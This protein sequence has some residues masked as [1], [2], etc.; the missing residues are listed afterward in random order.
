MVLSPKLGALGLLAL[1]AQASGT[2]L[3]AV[4]FMQVVADGAD[5]SDWIGES[6]VN[7]TGN[8]S[9][10][11]PALPKTQSLQDLK[12]EA[13]EMHERTKG[14]FTD[15]DGLHKDWKK[16]NIPADIMKT[17]RDQFS[18]AMGFA[19]ASIDEYLLDLK[20]LSGTM[21]N[22]VDALVE[23]MEYYRKAGKLKPINASS[24]VFTKEALEGLEWT[25]RGLDIFCNRTLTMY[26]NITDRENRSSFKVRNYTQSGVVAMNKLLPIMLDPSMGDERISTEHSLYLTPLKECHD[27]FKVTAAIDPDQARERLVSLAKIL[28]QTKES[29]YPVWGKRLYDFQNGLQHKGIDSL[30]AAT[31]FGLGFSD[32]MFNRTYKY[33]DKLEV[34][35]SAN[36]ALAEGLDR[37]GESLERA[38]FSKEERSKLHKG[39]AAGLRAGFPALLAATA[40]A[41]L[42]LSA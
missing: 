1:A 35:T 37:L 11:F 29:M 32:T 20:N 25:S 27:K 14:I 24:S 42:A 36:V 10:P 33:I 7:S 2:S 4:D 22:M 9:G 38:L 23:K 17:G 41:F 28:R 8:S 34:K 31:P 13:E 30:V 26:R 21:L 16:L 39:A 12:K 5:K 19:E 3:D 18:T 6:Q 40:S 15:K